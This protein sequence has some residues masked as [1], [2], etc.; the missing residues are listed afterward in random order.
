LQKISFLGAIMEY[1]NSTETKNGMNPVEAQ[2]LETAVNEAAILLKSRNLSKEEYEKIWQETYAKSQELLN[3]KIRM[4]KAILEIDPACGQRTDLLHHGNKVSK[5]D[6]YEALG[7]TARQ[8][9]D[10]QTIAKNPTAVDRAKQWASE[11]K[12]LITAYRVLDFIKKDKEETISEDDSK[13]TTS[14]KAKVIAEKIT[15]E[16]SN[17]ETS[18][19][20]WFEFSEDSDVLDSIKADARKVSIQLEVPIEIAQAFLENLVSDK[21]VKSIRFSVSK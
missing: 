11:N 6:V 14:S 7:L 13:S 17:T 9:A 15:L 20:E 3:Y 19:I 18:N 4:G 1:E 10:Y 2:A 8:A 21:D 5:K 12:E 16:S